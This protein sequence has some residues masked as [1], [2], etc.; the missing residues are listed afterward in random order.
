M[1]AW[2]AQRW[3][4]SRGQRT[5]HPGDA[6]SLHWAWG[7]YHMVPKGAR[8]RPSVGL[9]SDGHL[10]EEPCGGLHP[11]PLDTPLPS[12]C[13]SQ[14]LGKARILVPSSMKEVQG[15]PQHLRG[16][17]PKALTRSSRSFSFLSVPDGVGM[18]QPF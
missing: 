4:G 15:C 13:L 17:D 8:A 12:S 18:F 10:L 3:R 11:L 6:S 9:L 2:V 14:L 7:V 1:K 16:T 5:R